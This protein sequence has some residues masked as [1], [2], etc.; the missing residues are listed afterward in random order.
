M[1]VRSPMMIMVIDLLTLYLSRNIPVSDSF[2]QPSPH[3]T[4]LPKQPCPSCRK[5]NKAILSRIVN[6][7]Q[8]SDKKNTLD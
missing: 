3:K 5:F 2:L 8:L 7:H 1:N 4:T 6:H